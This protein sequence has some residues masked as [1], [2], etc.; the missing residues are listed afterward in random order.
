MKSEIDASFSDVER[1][2]WSAYRSPDASG[3]RRAFRM[4]LQYAIAGALVLAGAILMEEVWLAALLYAE[5]LVVLLLR[6]VGGYKIAGVMPGIIE[7]YEK[8]L[9]D[10]KTDAAPEGETDP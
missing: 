10:L 9:R 2:V 3:M 6:I 7:K 5:L 4:A 8:A 1:A